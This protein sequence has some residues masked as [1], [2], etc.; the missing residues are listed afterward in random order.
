MRALFWIILA[1]GPLVALAIW[2][3]ETTMYRWSLPLWLIIWVHLILLVF[4]LKDRATRSRVAFRIYLGLL[5]LTVCFFSLFRYEG[6]QS[7]SSMPKYVWRWSQQNEDLALALKGRS[8]K[9]DAPAI[10]STDFSLEGGEAV[11]DF[12]G[13]GRD[14]KFPE[15]KFRIDW[16]KAPP[17]EIWR[18]PIG[19]GWSSFVVGPKGRAITQEQVS[20]AESVTAL[21]LT[22]GS[23]IWTHRNPNT[24]LLLERRENAGARMGGDGPRSTPTI[25]EG[26]VYAIGSTG[27][28]DCLQLESGDS[29]WAKDLKQD[30]GSEVPRWGISAAPLIVEDHGYVLVAGQESEGPCF[31]ALD[32]ESGKLKWSI[33]AS[34]ASYSSPVRRT[35]AGIDQ[36][37]L[38]CATEVIGANPADGSILWSHPWKSRFPKVGQPQ[39]ISDTDILVTA[40][41]G[42]QSLRLSITRSDSGSFSEEELWQSNRMK[43]KFSTAQIWNNLAVGLDEGRLAAIDLQTGSKVWK[44]EKFGFGQNLLIADSLLVQAENGDVVV[45]SLSSSGFS[46]TGRI[47]TALSSMTWN[48]PSLAGRILLVRNDREAI[49]YRLPAA[50][51]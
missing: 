39:Q 45:G 34:G 18:S 15:R 29:I 49:A 50:D 4:T 21:S 14:G 19:R 31:F 23:I 6:S 9:P 12:L 3:I 11:T 46:E 13:P 7:G 28:V 17:E 8:A 16:A 27:K 24:R 26:K 25:H 43:T 44:K 37:I 10:S 33:S 38:I 20:D 41:Y 47:G 51:R 2:Q 35:I 32:L 1:L 5:A 42:M 48:A 40:S 22:D 36:L 30:F